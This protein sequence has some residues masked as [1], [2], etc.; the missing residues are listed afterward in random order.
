MRRNSMGSEVSA[1]FPVIPARCFITA[2][3]IKLG[4]SD[5]HRATTLDS[6]LRWNDDEASHWT[7]A[8][9]LTATHCFP[10]DSSTLSRPPL[11]LPASAMKPKV[12]L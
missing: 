8:R 9:Y 4:S 1:F 7:V 11:C 10:G 12:S 3:L 6:S 5:F 2:K